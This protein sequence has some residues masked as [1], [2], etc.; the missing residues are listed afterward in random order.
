LGLILAVGGIKDG[1]S[2]THGQGGW[3]L[4]RQAHARALDGGETG[5]GTDR[6]SCVVWGSLEMRPT[7]S[8][9]VNGQ[10]V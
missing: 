10:T 7:G 8:I 2:I 9:D 3:I 1:R 5:D 6:L 4:H